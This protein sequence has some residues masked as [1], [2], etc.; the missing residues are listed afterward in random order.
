LTI[1]VLR[2]PAHFSERL[3]H[4]GIAGFLF[5]IGAFLLLAWLGRIVPPLLDGSS[6]Y[7][8]ESY[9]T[10]PI[11]V[12]DLGVIVPLAVTAA[13]LLLKRLPAGYLLTSVAM[14]KGFTMGLALIAM[15]IGQILAGVAISTVE[16][17]VFTVIALVAAGLTFVLFKNV[18]EQ[19]II[20]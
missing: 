9:A 4:R 3:P 15:I 17:V 10:L 6:P 2:L 7:G 18:S 19:P 14:I 20:A 1:D 12:L 11:Q 16:S 13:I 5:T 8:L